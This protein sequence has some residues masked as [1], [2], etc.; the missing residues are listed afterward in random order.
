VIIDVIQALNR[1]LA[2]RV[3]PEQL[4]AADA[5]LRA[6]LEVGARVRAELLVRP[7]HGD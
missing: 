3:D 1:E 5:V 6:S 4:R 2:A 7:V